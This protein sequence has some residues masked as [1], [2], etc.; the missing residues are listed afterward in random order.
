LPSFHVPAP[1]LYGY[2]EIPDMLFLDKLF[3][4]FADILQ[5]EGFGDQRTYFFAFNITHEIFE[6]FGR[7]NGRANQF[8]VM[9]V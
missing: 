3:L 9:Q 4:C 7:A 2:D 1:A 5:R 8:Q 6:Y